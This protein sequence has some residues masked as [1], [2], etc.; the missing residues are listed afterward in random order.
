MFDYDE[1]LEM[2]MIGQ[3]AYGKIDCGTY[4]GNFLPMV[5]V[6]NGCFLFGKLSV[7]IRHL[8]VF[9]F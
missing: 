8:Q 5:T 7:N 4:R 9:V 3:G 1:V 2:V 6:S